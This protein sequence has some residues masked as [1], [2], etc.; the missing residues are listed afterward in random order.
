MIHINI[1]K[2]L[3]SKFVG[4]Y[5]L[6]SPWKRIWRYPRSSPDIITVIISRMK[7]M[8]LVAQTGKM[9]NEHTTLVE[10]LIEIHVHHFARQV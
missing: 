10:N 4:D 7:K 3:K 6:L 5:L 8:G 9:T 2:Q 1:S